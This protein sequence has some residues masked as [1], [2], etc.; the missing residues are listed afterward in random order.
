VARDTGSYLVVHA[1]VV[2]NLKEAAMMDMFSLLGYVQ[3]PDGNKD[4][5]VK[6][7]RT[8]FRVLAVGMAEDDD[9]ANAEDERGE[10][11]ETCSEQAQQAAVKKKKEKKK[12]KGKRQNKE[13][14]EDDAQISVG[15]PDRQFNRQFHRQFN[16]QFNKNISNQWM[17]YFNK[18]IILTS[19]SLSSVLI[20]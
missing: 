2:Q 9:G 10:A 5:Q 11:E 14:N 3:L 17:N 19:I 16:R 13:K 8:S 12:K 20:V 7:R 15:T 1:L 6:K 18:P 4:K